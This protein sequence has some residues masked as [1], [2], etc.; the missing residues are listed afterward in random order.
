MKKYYVTINM[1]IS[2]PIQQR[3]CVCEITTHFVL[4]KGRQD[5]RGEGMG[6]QS[7]MF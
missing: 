2:L 4:F 6:G 7:C 5:G 1:K 3:V